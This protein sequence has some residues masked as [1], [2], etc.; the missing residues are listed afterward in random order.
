MPHPLSLHH[1]TIATLVPHLGHANGTHV[2][3]QLP[4]YCLAAATASPHQLP[5]HRHT[6]ATPLPRHCH[7][8]VAPTAT[9]Q[10]LQPHANSTPSPHIRHT[11]ATPLARPTTPT[12]TPLPH[13][14]HTHCR[15]CAIHS[16]VCLKL[17]VQY[18]SK[19]VDGLMWQFRRFDVAMLN[20]LTWQLRWF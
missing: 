5:R 15:V 13:P 14:C 2:S 10:P 18:Y 4:R 17:L 20:G 19:I 1:H 7:A 11:T 12:A 6:C 9:L 16:A 3:Q 8:R